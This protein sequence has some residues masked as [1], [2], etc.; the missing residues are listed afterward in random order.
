MLTDAYQRLYDQLKTLIPEDRLIHDDLRTLAYG[1]DAS[2]YRYVPNLI[3]KVESEREV[4][5]TLQACRALGLAVTF[6]AAGTSL[7]GQ[8]C[9][10]SVLM[11]LGDKGWHDHA[12]ADDY[13]EI[14]LQ[15]GLRGVQANRLL[16]PY[17]KKIG[18]DPASIDSAKIGGIVANNAC[19]MASGIELNSQYTLKDI[20]L[21][22]ADGTVL[23]TRDEHSREAFLSLKKDWVER[24]QQ[25]STR[26]KSDPALVEKIQRKYK[27]K[28]TTGYSVNA[29]IEQDDPIKMIQ[30]LIVGSEGTL[31]FI[32]DVT[33]VTAEEP[34]TKATSLMLFPDIT[35]MCEAVLILQQCPV[36]A[37]ELMDRLALRTVEE[38]PGVPAY[39]KSLGPDVTA[40][41]VETAAGDAAGLEA[42]IA[43]IQEKL[44]PI[45]MAHEYHFTTDPAEA[46]ALWTVRKGIFPSACS[47]RP[48]G[49]AVI[50]EDIAVP[51]ENLGDCLLELQKL[52]TQY[53]YRNCVIWGHVFDGN[54]HFVLTP[55]FSDAAEIDKYKTFMN[56]VV[57]LVVDRYDG[58][59]KAEHGT[60]RNM[61]PFVA[62]E[63]GPEIYTVMRE[64]KDI[65]DPEHL[66]NPDVMIS[67]D[68]DIFVKQFK[69]MPAAHEIVDTCIECGFCE[70][71]CMSNDFTLSARQRIVIWREISELRRTAPDSPRLKKLERMYA[72]YGDKTCAADGLCA[73][74]C[75]V[76]INTGLLIKD[77]RAR[78]T[79]GIG[80]FM[81]T[82]IGGNMDRVTG[83]MRASLGMVDRVHRLLGSTV[84]NGAARGTRRLTFDRLPQWNPYMPGRADAVRPERAFYKGV[85]RIVYFPA[86]IAR[87]MGPARQDDP[88]QSLVHVTENLVRKAGYQIVYPEGM[89]N[90][91]CGMAFNS[92][93]FTRTATEKAAELE[94]ALIAASEGGNLPILCDTS[95]CLYHMKSTLDPSLKLYEP[96]EFTL[97]FLVERLNFDPQQT[98]VALHAVCSA[99][100]MGLEDK[101]VALAR[102]CASDIVL[103]EVNCCGFAGDKGFNVPELNA[104][105]LRRLKAQL[106]GEIREGYSTSRTCEI[107]LGLHGGIPYKSIL[108]LV[109]RV[110]QAKS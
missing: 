59:L 77:L 70:R 86:C 98:P 84:M 97:D 31:A 101:L 26:L 85:D 99:K 13:S 66:L 21:I 14:T 51:V 43:E 36:Q 72:Y 48:V 28:N 53:D 62:K 3:V 110:T 52:F 100:K 34:S 75:P 104:F 88:Q 42:N 94:E 63:W 50:I 44:K 33:F 67:D 27:I 89:D 54:V 46:A 102:M 93:G 69:P 91:C 74:S 8:A 68:P 16:A 60:G 45:E 73:L 56:E 109:D 1:T 7:S 25:L 82:Q 6:R 41:L 80:R 106:P 64:I 57:D 5:A 29:L 19:G 38:K 79:G 49:T 47:E 20:R 39:I 76:E 105:G 90:L 108:Y 24:L 87:T 78:Q 71:N 30:H 11:V 58:S 32:S 61:A 83:A 81:A 40:L 9:T 22:F 55:D 15:V 17:G 96:I 12:I 10:D 35:T 4:T 23:D 37:A 103:P 92:K 18:P 107:G 95:P 65:F 2:F